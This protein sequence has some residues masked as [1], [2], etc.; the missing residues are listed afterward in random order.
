MTAST[1]LSVSS[2]RT[3]RRAPAPIA[4]RTQISRLRAAERA[5]SRFATFT[6]AISSTSPTIA[7]RMASGSAKDSRCGEKP[8][9]AGWT[10]T[11]TRASGC[12]PPA[13]ESCRCNRSNSAA[14]AACA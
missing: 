5:S 11:Q 8:V 10:S 4:S 14:V 3:I 2:W 1:R 13:A 6:H 7:I 9:A 12:A